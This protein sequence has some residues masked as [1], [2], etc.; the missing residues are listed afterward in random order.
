MTKHAIPTECLTV[1]WTGGPCI[2]HM[3][4][5]QQ[6]DNSS[7]CAS[8]IVLCGHMTGSV[9][10]Y[11]HANEQAVPQLANAVV[12][13]QAARKMWDS[14]IANGFSPDSTVRMATP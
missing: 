6:A 7:S 10:V 5:D 4:V 13:L 2:V 9:A 14:L 1:Q 3:L 12:P 11:F 8:F